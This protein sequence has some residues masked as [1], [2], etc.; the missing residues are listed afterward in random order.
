MGITPV[1][2]RILLVDDH[3]DTCDVISRL[4]SKHGYSVATAAN[5]GSALALA[6]HER[7]D[8]LIADVGLPDGSGLDL[9]HDIRKQYPLVGIVVSGFGMV[10]DVAK[11][12]SAGYATHLTKP[13]SIADLCLAVAS[14]LTMQRRDDDADGGDESDSSDRRICG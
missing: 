9:L 6:K 11:S 3:T 4:L 13:V 8:L 1:P 7:F 12:K 14:A 2:I 10:S 5:Y